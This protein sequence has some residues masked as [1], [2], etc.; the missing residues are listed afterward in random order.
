M[1]ALAFLLLLANPEEEFTALVER[2]RQAGEP[3]RLEE[4]A[5]PPIPDEENSAAG[6]RDADAWRRAHGD[7]VGVLDRA[8]FSAGG[9]LAAE[10]RAAIQSALA[11]TE[12][13]VALLKS[14]ASRPRW[15]VARDWSQGFAA[16][17]G[18]IPWITDAALHLEARIRFDPAAGEGEERASECV[19]LLLGLQERVREPYYVG[20]VVSEGFLLRGVQL[21]QLA[22]RREGCDAGKL[23]GRLDA[24]LAR[25]VAST[26]P[27]KRTFFEE[28]AA[29]LKVLADWLE[30]KRTVAFAD[31][32]ELIPRGVPR[33]EIVADGVRY[34]RFMARA[35]EECEVSAEAAVQAADRL[36][37]DPLPTAPFL[38]GSALL[39]KNVFRSYVAR[40][41][42]VRLAR[43]ALALMEHRAA[44]G[45]W[46][47]SLDAI[48]DRFEGGMPLDP[49][50][51]QPFAYKA[52]G[53]GARVWALHRDPRKA[54]SEEELLAWRWDG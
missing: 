23:R 25:A 20:H 36:A 2:I 17:S 14:A 49:Y 54:D 33:D 5:T 52:E 10:E 1:S 13:Y 26:G 27:P 34:L 30:G 37:S 16:A 51:G 43:V 46:P 19:A 4:L 32:E 38:H 3:T 45:A 53:G 47:A 31:G 24:K 22:L 21:L 41:A 6:L 44:K 28:R 40:S 9:A 15:H 48:A 29:T 7:V 50:T 8:V 39:A 11:A 18:S 42:A 35:I 12:P